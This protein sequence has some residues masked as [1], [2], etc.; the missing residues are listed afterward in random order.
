MIFIIVG[1]LEASSRLSI[2]KVSDRVDIDYHSS[3][4]LVEIINNLDIWYT[5][6]NTYST[7]KKQIRVIFCKKLL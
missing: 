5:E 1:K 3:I 7:K 6:V 2:L 4:A